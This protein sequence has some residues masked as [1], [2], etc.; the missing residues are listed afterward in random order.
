MITPHRREVAL[1]DAGHVEDRAAPSP[2]RATPCVTRDRSISS[3][4]RCG[5]EH[6][7]DDGRRAHR[8]QRGGDEVER[9]D[10][11]QRPARQAE[12]GAGEPELGDVREVLPRQV[13]VGDHHALRAARWCP[14]CT[15]A[16]GRRRPA[17]GTRAGTRGVARRDRRTRSQPSDVRRRRCTRGRGRRRAP[18]SLRWRAST[19]ASSHTSARRFRVL[20]DEPQLRR[21]EPPVDRHRDRAEVVGGEDRRRGTRCCCTRAARRR[22]RRR[23]R[24]RA[25]RPRAPPP[26]PPSR[27]R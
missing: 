27:R 17:T 16:G 3:T 9:A 8:D 5:V 6:A 13:G 1:L 22:R 2:A 15:S 7:V 24:A 4:T 11:V 12:V 20:E 23:R 21:R 26:T 14:T 19:S 10:V 18:S 25:A